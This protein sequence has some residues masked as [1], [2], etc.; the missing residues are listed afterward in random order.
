MGLHRKEVISGVT[1]HRA[2]LYVS[3]DRNALRRFANYGS[4]AL[5]ASMTAVATIRHVDAVWV[6]ATPAT[7]AL[8]AIVLRSLGVPYV[9]HVQDL[10]P[11]TVT[12]SG[13]LSPRMSP[14]IAD[15]LHPLCDFAYRYASSVQVTAPGMVE[16]IAARGVARNKIGFLP[17]WCDETIFQPRPRRSDLR[18]AL[19]LPSGFTV[20]YAGAIGEVQ[21][22]DVVIEAADLL[23]SRSEIN[24]VLV[25]SGVA[26]V[27]LMQE[28]AQRKLSNIHF[29]PAQPISAMG[30]I[31]ALSDV[32]LICLR[33]LP[34]YRMTLPSKLQATMAAGR[35]LVVSASGDAAKVVKDARAGI[36][37][38]PGSAGALAKAVLAA[39]EAGATQRS[40]W[41][42]SARDHYL[43]KYSESV[44][45]AAMLDALARASDGRGGS[46]LI[47]DRFQGG[48]RERGRP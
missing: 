6:H 7:A 12:A 16:R 20:M 14:R 27:R 5:S 46:V 45:V 34:L 38:R 3:H 44:G 9:L 23:R 41:G 21:G 10:W 35:P 39:F 32:Q 2:P 1:V 15:L 8:P 42:N 37:V 48:A 11:D 29:V 17:N 13:F 19:G 33:D 25:G 18:T 47:R 43:S 30:D 26:R 24:F 40:T 36:S 31:L 28:A 4:F 22:L